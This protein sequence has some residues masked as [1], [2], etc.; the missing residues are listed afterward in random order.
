MKYVYNVMLKCLMPLNNC[1]ITIIHTWFLPDVGIVPVIY[2]P[3]IL[4]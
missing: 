4:A 1:G 2:L 3:G